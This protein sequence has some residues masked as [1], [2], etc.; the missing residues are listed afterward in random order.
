MNGSSTEILL[1]S[2]AVKYTGVYPYDSW[3]TRAQFSV[4]K[5]WNFPDARSSH[6]MT[7]NEED[8][9]FPYADYI[10][11]RK[12]EKRCEILFRAASMPATDHPSLILRTTLAGFPATIVFAGTSFVTTL[13]EPTIAFSPIVT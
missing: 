9:L 10:S 4:W 6:S 12:S 7:D 1:F 2:D 11:M 13:P 8:L 3:R 5:T